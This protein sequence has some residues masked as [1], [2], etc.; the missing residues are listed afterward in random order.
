MFINTDVSVTLRRHPEGDWVG[1]DAATYSE[2]DGVGMSDTR[3]H[4]ERGMIGRANQ[5]LLVGP[6]R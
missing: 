2:P 1:L 3:L 5:T 6:R 4:D